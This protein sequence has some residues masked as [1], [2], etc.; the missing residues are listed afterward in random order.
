MKRIDDG[1]DSNKMHVIHRRCV[2]YGENNKMCMF[3]TEAD[4]DS[5]STT[6][7]FAALMQSVEDAGDNLYVVIER[8]CRRSSPLKTVYLKI[9]EKI[10]SRN[11]Y[12]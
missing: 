11:K 4:A 6:S 7:Y 5:N 8:A 10:L 2:F 12:H 1:G 9:R 3:I